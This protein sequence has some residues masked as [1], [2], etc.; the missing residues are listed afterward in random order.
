MNAQLDMHMQRGYTVVV[1]PIAIRELPK[2]GPHTS[3]IVCLKS[4]F[5]W[6]LS[7]V[8]NLNYRSCSK[9]T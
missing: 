5:G 2:S 1:L 7:A 6:L 8:Q 9:T 3:V 4:N